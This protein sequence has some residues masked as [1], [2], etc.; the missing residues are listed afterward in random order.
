MR[1]SFTAALPFILIGVLL[2]ASS[3]LAEDKPGNPNPLEFRYDTALWAVVVF[4]G[5][6]LILQ[7]W[8]W[9]P[10]LEGLKKREETILGAIE[11]ATVHRRRFE[12]RAP[13]F[14]RMGH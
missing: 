12:N 7:K 5:L 2:T 9:G 10:I 4:V 3:A 8:A 13:G 1:I 11:E 6:L 14:R